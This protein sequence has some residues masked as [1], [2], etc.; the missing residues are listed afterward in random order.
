[1]SQK[2]SQ[3]IVV[4]VFTPM[5]EHRDAI[6]ELLARVTPIVHDEPGCEFYTMNEDVEG[7]FVHIEAWTTRQHWVEHIAKPSV[8]E[9]LAGVEGKL[10]RDVE[11]YEMYNVPTGDSGKGSLAASVPSP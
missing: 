8:K 2:T 3:C 10:T 11:V 9:I 6:R 7:R 1:M 4:A 5:D